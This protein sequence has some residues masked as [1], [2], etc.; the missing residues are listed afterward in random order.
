MAQVSGIDRLIHYGGTDSLSA[1]RQAMLDDPTALVI[2][3]DDG[4]VAQ[5]H[6]LHASEPLLRASIEKSLGPSGSYSIVR[7]RNELL[8]TARQLGI[9]VPKTSLVTQADDL[10]KWHKTFATGGVLKV[11]GSCGGHGVRVSQSLDQSMAAWRSMSAR[12]NIATA[13]KRWVID[14]DPL[15]LWAYR[16]ARD[17]DV[18][19]QEFIRGRPANLMMAC[20]GG[21]VLA[22]VS[23]EVVVSEG[24]TGAATIVRPIVNDTMSQAASLLAGRLGLCGFYGLD[25]MIQAGTGVPF[26]IEMNPRCTQLGHLDFPGQ[27]SLASVLCA[28]LRDERPSPSRSPIRSKTIA[29]FPQALAASA[30]SSYLESAYLDVPWEDPKL[31]RELQFDPWPQRQWP[32]RLYLAFRPLKRSQ[33]TIYGDSTDDEA[34]DF[35]NSALNS[36]VGE[37]SA[38]DDPG[39]GAT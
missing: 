34:A 31:L 13:L 6:A 38:L 23:V 7:S 11:D 2:P 10:A 22:L 12:T 8:A 21:R 16:A 5:L 35:E 15:A 39:G 27:G 30:G 26:L 18:T 3:C 29:I 20:W 17:R 1:L 9:T 33:P 19:I 24:P 14:R 32:A 4:V 28:A 37:D 36:C 25:F